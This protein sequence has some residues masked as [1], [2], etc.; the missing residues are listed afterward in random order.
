M[1]KLIAT[2]HHPA[3]IDLDAG[4]DAAEL[5]SLVRDRLVGVPE[6]VDASRL[7]DAA[8]REVAAWFDR[9]DSDRLNDRQPEILR[10]SPGPPAGW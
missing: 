6:L 9:R 10:A 3:L 2:W 8:L 7:V 1:S 5:L 4:L